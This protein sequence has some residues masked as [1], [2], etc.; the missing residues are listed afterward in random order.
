[1]A[2]KTFVKLNHVTNLSDARYAAGMGVTQ[3]GFSINPDSPNYIDTETMSQIA[4]WITGV[5]IVYE[6]DTIT[7]L[8]Q[9]SAMLNGHTIQL[10]EVP[11]S[12]EGLGNETNIIIEQLLEEAINNIRVLQS[13]GEQLKYVLL[14][15]EGDTLTNQMIDSIS[16]LASK[17][18]VVLGFGFNKSS[19]NNLLEEVNIKG[20]AIDSS[21]EIRPGFKDYDHIAD[22]LEALEIE[23]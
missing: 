10:V 1:M 4:D 22:I 11:E 15:G 5:D 12:L 16:E 14:T 9:T 7:S 2:L 13:Y 3:L 23:D 21:K 17:I 20:I 18:P 19:V 8:Q 6:C